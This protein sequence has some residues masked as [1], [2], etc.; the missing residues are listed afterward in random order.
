MIFCSNLRCSIVPYPI[1]LLYASPYHIALKQ[2]MCGVIIWR[3]SIILFPIYCILHIGIFVSL[4]PTSKIFTLCRDVYDVVVVNPAQTVFSP[5][6]LW[7]IIA[8]RLFDGCCKA[9]SYHLILAVWLFVHR[10]SREI[11]HLAKCTPSLFVCIKVA[12]ITFLCRTF[13][14]SKCGLV[15]ACQFSWQVKCLIN[16]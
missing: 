15:Q 6:T 16:L 5:N 10:W 12:A 3:C 2:I 13:V 14:A 8:H 9:L 1:K 7:I 4:K 11:I